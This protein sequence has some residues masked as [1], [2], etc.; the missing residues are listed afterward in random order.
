GIVSTGVDLARPPA[1]GR[2]P[3]H[4]RRRRVRRPAR[5]PAGDRDAVWGGPR[6]VWA[7][8]D[9]VHRPRRRREDPARPGG[10]PGRG[11]AAHAGA[12]GRELGRGAGRI[13]G[14]AGD[15][16]G[17]A[18]GRRRPPQPVPGPVLPQRPGQRGHVGGPRA[19]RR[20]RAR[21]GRDAV[22]ALLRVPGLH[23]V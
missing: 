10:P 16:G 17:G 20:L 13:G 22:G 6:R 1:P 5:G 18:R 4:L 12:R 21:L 8:P 2:R 7:G 23:Q 9:L 14:T 19:L 3:G 11:G 15:D